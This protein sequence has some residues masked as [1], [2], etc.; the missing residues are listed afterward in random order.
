M[1]DK[2]HHLL[3]SKKNT[4]ILVILLL[5]AIIVEY[6]LSNALYD[7]N[8]LDDKIANHFLTDFIM[9]ET[10]EKGQVSW[11]LEGKRLEKFPNSERSEVT[12]PSMRI[13]SV[14]HGYWIVTAKK[15]LDPDSLFKS[16]YLYGDV[17]FIKY[18]GEEKK[19]MDI[20]TESAVIY[21]DEEKVE[22]DKFGIIKT[23]DSKTSGEGIIADINNGYVKILSKAK[24]LSFDEN[25]TGQIEGDK[26]IYDMGNKSWK[27]LKKNSINN[28]EIK[29]RVRTILKTRN[30]E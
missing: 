4:Y 13:F 20:S 28:T 25:K 11:I 15:A 12:G 10:D 22:T 6:I 16:I 26:L 27:V 29:E 30:K 19:E 3:G 9:T 23:P 2:L 17:T 8:Q 24:R 18:D 7:D 21:P 14:G 5:S 1:L